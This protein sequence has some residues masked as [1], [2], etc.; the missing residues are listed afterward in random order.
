[1]LIEIKLKSVLPVA[2]SFAVLAIALY[3]LGVGLKPN[4][5]RYTYRGKVDGT[6]DA[7][8]N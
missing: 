8:P 1:M 7:S 3:R 4:D 2:F 5:D 6:S